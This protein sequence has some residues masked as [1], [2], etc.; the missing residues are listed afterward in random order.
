MKRIYLL[1]CFIVTLSIIFATLDKL[2]TRL[3]D[4]EQKWEIGL[5]V[6]LTGPCAADGDSTVK[7]AKL[8]AKELNTRGGVLGR[9]VSFKI[10]DT[11]EATSGAKAVTAYRSVRLNKELQFLIGP[12]WTPG[13]LALAPLLAKDKNI[14]AMSPSLGVSDYNEA[15]DNIF[16]NRGADAIASRKLAQFAISRG[17]KRVAIMSSQ[18]PWEAAQAAY[19]AEEF[20]RNG[21]TITVKVEPLPTNTQLHAEALKIV[22]SKPEAIFY[23]TV[24]QL[25]IV[26][27]ELKNLG[28]KGPQI[29]AYLDQTR[30]E[31][32]QGA[33]DGTFSSDLA[34]PTAEFQTKFAAAYP[35]AKLELPAGTA[36]DAVMLYA[37]AIEK[38]QSFKIETV[39][40]ALLSLDYQGATGRIIFDKQ[41]GANRSPA[42]K[43]LQG[44]E[45]L[46][47]SE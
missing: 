10:E 12:T 16:N 21:G 34:E 1:A 44:G 45:Y 33:L 20:E 39:K 47:L 25:A 2:R 28:F 36:Y 30:I 11:A 22:N 13:G 35:G 4:T 38:A 24:V 42:L 17:W 46:S 23:S 29:A 40:Q 8:A 26:A 37:K 19:F 27:K 9:K 41:G 43:Q 31:E 6:C 14:L 32:A 18:Q 15:S 7:G 3:S 5:V